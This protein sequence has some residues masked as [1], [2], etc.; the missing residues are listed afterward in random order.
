MA[1]QSTKQAERLSGSSAGSK[2]LIIRPDHYSIPTEGLPKKLAA[3]LARK[4]KGYHYRRSPGE[5][6]CGQVPNRRRPCDRAKIPPFLTAEQRLSEL[7]AILA[8]GIL[9]LRVRAALPDAES[10]VEFPPNSGAACLDVP[11]KTVLSVLA[12]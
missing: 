7:A 5:G 10:V 2:K 4:L 1:R 6:R 8:A 3:I 9:R 12:G 11:A